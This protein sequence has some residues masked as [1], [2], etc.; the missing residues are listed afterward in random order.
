MQ[1]YPGPDARFTR[2][3]S[4][5]ASP[6]PSSLPGQTAQQMYNIPQGT[7]YYYLGNNALMHPGA[8]TQYAAPHQMYPTTGLVTPNNPSS[9]APHTVSNQYQ[10]KGMYGNSYVNPYDNA[11][12][13]GNVTDYVN[14]N[15]YSTGSGAGGPNSAPTGGKGS[16]SSTGSSQQSTDMSSSMY[17]NKGHL[18]KMNVRLSLLL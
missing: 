9:G 13:T 10:N 17:G 2:S 11:A 18:N 12:Q 7:G 15:S 6:V 14:K 16:S 4:S 1:S 5:A 3:D 8:F